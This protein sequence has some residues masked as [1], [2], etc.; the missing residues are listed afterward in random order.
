VQP[1]RRPAAP[2]GDGK[3]EGRGSLKQSVEAFRHRNFALFWTGALL[4]NTGGWIQNVTVPYVLFQMTGSATWVGLAAFAQLFPTVILGPLSGSIADRFSRRRTL[5]VTQSF[6]AAMA[7]VLWGLWESGAASPGLILAVVMLFGLS[8]GLSIPS[9]Q[10]FVTE[11]VPRESLLNAITLNS[12]QFNAA[13]ALG[14]TIGGAVLATLGPSWAFLIN[15]FSYVAVLGALALVRVAPLVRRPV[16]GRVLSQFVEGVRFTRRHSGLALVIALVAAVGLLGSPVFQLTAVF[17]S[18][19]FDVG[20]GWYGVLSGALGVGAVLSA[21]LIGGWGNSLPRSRLAG[22]A[23]VIYA[24][25]ITCFGLSPG[26]WAGMAALLVAGGGYLAVVSTLQT[27]LQLLVTEEMRGRVLALYFM[28]FTASYPI[29]S[30]I[31]GAIADRVGAPATVT[32]AGLLLLGLAAL[33]RLRPGLLATLDEPGPALFAPAEG[34]EAVEGV[35]AVNA[36][37]A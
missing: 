1:E 3:A 30:L 37:E 8:G 2:N 34:E 29:G 36:V 31:Q 27:T 23:L 25:A 19:V 15:G 10:A 6:A 22:L 28:A 4:S 20:P 24:A 18:E 35:E 16:E 13:R 33:I 17:A 26:V 32:C 11:L 5:M 14:P 21:P 7:F 9:W 12:A